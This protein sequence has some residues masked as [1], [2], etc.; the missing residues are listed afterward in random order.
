MPIQ[1]VIFISAHKHSNKAY[2]TTITSLGRAFYHR[3]LAMG[4]CAED[5]KRFSR[6]LKTW[7]YRKKVN[8]HTEK[9]WIG[10]SN[11]WLPL[12]VKC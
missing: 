12:P 2:K 6:I 9:A 11:N 10:G 5:L 4:L 3:Q 8:G 7:V 1:F